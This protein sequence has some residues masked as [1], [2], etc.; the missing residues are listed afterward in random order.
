MVKSILFTPIFALATSLSCPETK[1][2]NETKEW[3]KKDQ[4]TMDF[5]KDRCKD[6]YKGN[7]CL[8]QFKKVEEGVYSALCG[9]KR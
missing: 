9:Q 6:V 1:L 4:Q 8:V 7:P 5:A 3:T 2:I